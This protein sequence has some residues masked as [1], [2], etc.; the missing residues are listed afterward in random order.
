MSLAE[1]CILRYRA[2]GHLR[3]QIPAELSRG[4]PAKR[5]EREIRSLEGVYRVNVYRRQRKLSIRYEP[6]VCEFGDLVRELRRIVNASE[7]AVPFP[8]PGKALQPRIARRFTERLSRLRPVRWARA[9]MLET[10]ET[11]A[12][13]GVLAKAR[14]KHAPELV[15][16]RERFA[17]EFFND[18]LVLYLIKVHWNLITQKWLPNPVR[19]RYAWL[20]VFYLFYL[21]VRWRRSAGRKEAGGSGRTS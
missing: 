1:Q 16:D 17:I 10:K 20:A 5:L 21:L 15:Q 3:F 7:R 8:A 19:N 13:L 6:T 12:A 2:A 9:K 11:A 18:V 4:E 14:L